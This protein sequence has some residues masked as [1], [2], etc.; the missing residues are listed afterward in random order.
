MIKNDRQYR[1]AKAQLEKFEQS[2]TE[3]RQSTERLP[4]KKLQEDALKSQ[5]EDLKKEI[6]EYESIWASNQSIPELESFDEIPGAL[7][8]ARLSQ[9][10]S[11]KQLADRL[12]L[13]EQQIQRYESSEYETASLARIKE[14]I[15]ALGLKISPRV[16][17]TTRVP[18]LEDFIKK[19]RD[20]G[21]ERDFI[22]ER[23][24]PP[25]VT[26]V[27]NRKSPLGTHGLQAAE[28]VGRIFHWT[29]AQ[30]FSREPLEL[31]YSSLGAKFK[32]RGRVRNP[33]LAV[34]AFYA[35]YLAMTVIQS[36]QHL[37][38]KDLPDNPY[39][40]HRHIVQNGSFSL[41]AALRFVWKL[42][43][44]VIPITDSAV[45]QGACFRENNRSAIIVKD[46][47]LSGAR[48][49]FDLFHEFWHA[50]QHQKDPS[51]R[52]LQ[53]EDIRMVA[54][55]DE[56]LEP[57][58]LDASSFASAVLL[59]RNP[60]DLVQECV[61]L[62]E[63]D[64]WKMKQAVIEVARRRNVST[65]ALANCVAFRLSGEGQDWWGAAENLQ[66]P[67]YD[68]QRNA[69]DVLLE[70]VDLSRLKGPDLDLLRRGL[71]YTE[72]VQ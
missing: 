60:D 58:E 12:G 27:E 49:A 65:S 28:Q 31:N 47:T 8:K 67:E 30:I 22:I 57:E 40:I 2:L 39:E 71:G 11:Q 69:R 7:I 38:A 5:I 3:T 37:E 4:I 9:G 62:A 21:L 55:R 54:S 53:F 43:V 20:V 63:R 19:L 52:F 59:G 16:Q 61:R 72:V 48:W 50:A 56:K 70:F 45:F 46:R 13:A 36:V 15:S 23:L 29:S 10:L 26:Q 6:E 35:Q 14:L 41:E 33:Q 1:I 64:I 42:G 32:L 44:P 18:S 66:E 51:T 24:L 17:P 68:I 25:S 34:H